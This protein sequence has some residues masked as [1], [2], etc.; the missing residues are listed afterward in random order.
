[1][2]ELEESDMRLIAA[3][4]FAAL[5][6]SLLERMIGFCRALQHEV[7]FL[8]RFGARGAPWDFNLRDLFRWCELMTAEQVC[9]ASF[10]SRKAGRAQSS[11]FH[12][13]YLCSCRR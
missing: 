8:R 3:N 11:C 13:P 12:H 4:H 9:A 6:A 1:M 10:M 7:V 2:E 5:P